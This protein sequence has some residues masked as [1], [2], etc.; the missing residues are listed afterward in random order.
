[1]SK[2]A[3]ERSGTTYRVVWK[4]PPSRFAKETFR[5][6]RAGNHRVILA[7]P[8]DEVQAGHCDVA[9][10]IEAALRSR[11]ERKGTVIA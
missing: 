7:C 3:K 9:T 11:H 4:A 6:I 5:T 10:R 1:M 8:T 2:R